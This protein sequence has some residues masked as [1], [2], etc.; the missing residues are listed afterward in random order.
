MNTIL[1]EARRPQQKSRSHE[2]RSIAPLPAT[3]NEA[4]IHMSSKIPFALMAIWLF[5][6]SECIVTAVADEASQAARGRGAGLAERMRQRRQRRE[7]EMNPKMQDRRIKMRQK[8]GS[9][10]ADKNEKMVGR[11]NRNVAQ[12]ISENR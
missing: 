1:E 2:E 6:I 7:E 9:G 8:Q 4:V 10:G 11:K 12:K 3:G 5:V